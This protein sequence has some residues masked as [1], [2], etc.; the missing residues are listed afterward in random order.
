[1]AVTSNLGCPKP[2]FDSV[3]IIVQKLQA[4][5]GPRDTNIVVN[6]P[7]QLNA[8]ALGSSEASNFVWTPPTGLNN[9]DIPNP[10][11]ILS[12]SQTYVLTVQSPAGCMA[13]DTISVTVYKISPG[14]YVPNGFTPNGDGIND[15]FKPILVGMKS[16]TYFRVY[17]RDGQLI[18]STNIQNQGWDGT[19]HG[20]PQDANVYVWM[21]EGVDYEGNTL[22]RKGSVT[23]VR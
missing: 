11:A 17:N 19:F 10:V 1:V 22:Y 12:N 14:I 16:L 4:D 9:P 18:Y 2:S 15:V 8:T 13:T 23:L 5:A 20:I 6:Q 21:A 3:L 7:L